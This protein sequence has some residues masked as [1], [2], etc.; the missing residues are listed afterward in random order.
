MMSN[1]NF[2]EKIWK[3]NKEGKDLDENDFIE[4]LKDTKIIL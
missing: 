2:I 3:R 4:C 1:E